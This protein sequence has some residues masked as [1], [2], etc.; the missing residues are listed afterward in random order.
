MW[1]GSNALELNEAT[2][3]AALQ[4]WLDNKVVNKDE[5]GPIVKSVKASQTSGGN[6]FRVDLEERKPHP[7]QNAA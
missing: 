3:I 2:M 1:I 4:Y 6:L 5:S 7:L